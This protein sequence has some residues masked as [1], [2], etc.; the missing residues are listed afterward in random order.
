[1]RQAILP[2]AV[3]AAAV[4][5]R[6]V[7]ARAQH[8]V[9]SG[10]NSIVLSA[11]SEAG[12]RKGMTGK[13]C[14]PETVGGHIVTNCSARFV[15]T[16]VTADKSIAQITKGERK[17]D[18]G[19][20]ANFDQP[21]KREAAKAAPRK[22][23]EP[24]PK[25][26]EA[27]KFLREADRAFS[28]GDYPG[29][30]E[31]Y[32]NFLHAYP[33]HERADF[34]AERVYE[35]RAKTAAIP[36]PPPLPL[37]SASGR[38]ADGAS[39]APAA[40]P[41]PI[42]APATML[43]P[44]PTLAPV[45]AAASPVPPPPAAPAEL[46][47]ADEQA[48]QAEHLFEGGRLGE[49]RA[50]ALAALRN[51]STN[52]R[53]RGT[54]RAVQLKMVQ[55]RFNGPTDLA[56]GDAGCY[57]ADA[58]NN[59]I[60]VIKADGLATVAGSA[61]QY[62]FDDGPAPR[63]RFNEPNGVA[64]ARDGTVYVC[65]RYNATIRQITTAGIVATVAGRA[66]IAGMADGPASTARFNAPR[67]IAV[68]Q[69]GTIYVADTGNHAVRKIAPGGTV[70][71]IFKSVM[72]DRMDPVGL[73]INAEGSLLVADVWSHVIRKI[74]GSGRMSIAA[75]LPGVSGSVDGPVGSA[76]FNSP[77]GVAVDSEGAI[78]V[79]DT[80]NH[81][82]RKIVNGVVSTVV[83]RAGIADIIDGSG[84]GARLNHPSGI[85]CDTQGRLWIADSGNHAI[86]LMTG[87]FVETVAGLPGSVG[88][89]DGTN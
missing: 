37:Q 10:G 6:P 17:V 70:E 76:R 49:A 38:A 18:P 31:R 25:I 68:S 32:E 81:T 87:E 57:V 19:A 34:A 35:A 61:G 47:Q 82:I 50:S 72:S 67:R 9:T 16:S 24:A 86:R 33:H 53:A 40:A 45:P 75:G 79:A 11:G 60:R 26:D 7:T 23:R 71:T 22:R 29:A 54:L 21:L 36:S 43:A 89:N 52:A 56:V 59:T 39:T 83:G 46:R 28:E 2:I 74:D 14:A 12:V 69:D 48:A 64:V 4:L 65:D 62:G 58:G 3:I 30:I 8:V 15:V 73:T 55:S 44:T 85:R 66:G 63:A 42:P 84:P 41:V 78:Y 5:L 20:I 88:S 1:V 27:T 51:D 80:E 77:E 13:T